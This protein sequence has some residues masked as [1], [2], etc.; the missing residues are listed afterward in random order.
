MNNL[1]QLPKMKYIPIDEIEKGNV[2]VNLG[3]VLEIERVSNH[4]NLI[5][6]RLKE[7]QVIKFQN[8]TSLIIEY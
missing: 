4:V 1:N 8:N 6:A 2:V 5:I 3:E 7:K